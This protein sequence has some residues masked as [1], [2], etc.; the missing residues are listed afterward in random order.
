MLMI[1]KFDKDY[2]DKLILFLQECFPQSGRKLELDGRHRM[3]SNIDAFFE[4]F[5][6]LFDENDIIGTVAL[7]KL[8]EEKCELK[9]LYLLQKY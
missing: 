2:N 9:S 7:K 4:N 5:W 8:D 6:C 1:K 3:Y